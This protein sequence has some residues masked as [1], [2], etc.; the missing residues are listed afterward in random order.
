MKAKFE[1]IS[2]I[3]DLEDINKI[4]YKKIKGINKYIISKLL[5][6]IYDGDFEI[7]KKVISEIYTNKIKDEILN[8]ENENF[9]KAKKIIDVFLK[10]D[11]KNNEWEYTKKY[12][13]DLL[14]KL[15][16]NKSELTT[17]KMIRSGTRYYLFGNRKEVNINDFINFGPINPLINNW[18]IIK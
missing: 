6:V 13:Y 10:E 8:G 4:V 2:K 3:E 5:Y 15:N 11:L 18:F 12:V 7:V 16:K 14:K 1:I 17:I 9:K